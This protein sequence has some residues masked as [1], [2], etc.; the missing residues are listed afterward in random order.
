MSQSNN[1]APAMPGGAPIPVATED[2]LPTPKYQSAEI[3]ADGQWHVTSSRGAQVATTSDAAATRGNAVV[4]GRD[5]YGPL[6]AHQVT[7]DSV[8]D[9]PSMGS[10]MTVRSALDAGLVTLGND[11]QYRL[12]ADAAR[13]PRG[14]ETTDDGFAPDDDATN[15]QQQQQTHQDEVVSQ[16]AEEALTDLVT[17]TGSDVQMAVTHEAAQSGGEISQAAIE[18][19]AAE[20]GMEPG[21]V[22]ERVETVRTAFEGQAR[23]AFVKGSGISNPE[24]VQ[25][26]IDMSEEMFPE[27]YQ[28]AISTQLT[29]RST[30]GY[31]AVARKAVEALGE[32]M[33][34]HLL[35]IG[36]LGPGVSLSKDS[37]G[38]VIVTANDKTMSWRQ[39][40]RTKLIKLG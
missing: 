28:Q 39:A 32:T 27:E 12:T 36:N 5:A 16:P 40:I 25:G 18:A 1:A 2:E 31:Q 23:Q 9:I 30:A 11:G 37:K 22:Q 15:R 35:Q 4:R 21:Q 6:Q 33:P 8:I 13:Q 24:I 26:L 17:K 10:E 3:G 34:D 38:H 19:L 29:Q 20:A 7:D 14:D